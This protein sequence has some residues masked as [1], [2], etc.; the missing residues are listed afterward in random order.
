MNLIKVKCWNDI[1][2]NYT[3]ITEYSN[4]DKYWYLNGKRHRNDGPAIEFNDG[5][6]HWF[7]KDRLHREDGPAV[8]VVNGDRYWYFNGIE[9]S[10]EEWFEQLS[11]EDKLKAIWNLR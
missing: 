9:Y 1:P 4:G 8:E 11:D 10:Q 2:E 6:K 7:F 3:G 5:D